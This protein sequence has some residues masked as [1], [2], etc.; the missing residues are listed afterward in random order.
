MML[1]LK[2]KNKLFNHF[3]ADILKIHIIETFKKRKDF[4]RWQINL[5]FFLIKD[6]DFKNSM[7]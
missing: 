2:K 1:T 6:I 5:D 4:D 3:K 7:T